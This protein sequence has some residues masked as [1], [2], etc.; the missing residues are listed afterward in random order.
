MIIKNGII[1]S[2]HGT[3]IP[4]NLT[5]QNEIISN[6][7]YSNNPITTN[8]DD[9][10]L[11]DATDCYVIPGLTD[12]H[13]HGCL[14][15]DFCDASTQALDAITTYEL[16]NGITTITP[17][18]MTLSKERLAKI[19]KTAVDYGKSPYHKSSI[20]GFYLEGPFLSY[21]KKGA[22]NPNFLKA[23]DIPFFQQLQSIAKGNIKVVA[24]APEQENAM[25][26]IKA[27]HDKVILSLA[28]T[29]CNYITALQAIEN[30]A[31][32]VTHLYNAM[33]GL[34]HRAPGVIGAA[35]DSKCCNVE[36]ICDGIHVDPCMIRLT[37]QLF[38]DDRII[39]ISDS[40][41]AAGMSDGEYSLGNQKVIVKNSIALLEDGTIAGSTTNLYQCMCNAI[42]MGIPK[43]SAIKAACVNPIKALG[44]YDSYGSISVGKQANLLIVTKDFQRKAIIKDGQLVSNTSSF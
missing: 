21:E 43:E 26:F 27:M 1:F 8:T 31:R 36:L 44:Q 4:G 7:D 30:G 40:M 6:I 15:Y 17:A 20:I 3:F 37:F 24:I 38:G 9:D 32:Q 11:I 35:F 22:Q 10:I 16:S 34:H 2:E 28:H 18:T 23:P 39:F 12:M 5:V 14:G 25:A 19:I 29:N 33:P 42:Q 13:F 41:S